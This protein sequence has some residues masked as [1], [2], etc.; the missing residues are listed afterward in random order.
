MFRIERYRRTR[1]WAVYEADELLCVAV[2]KKGATAVKERLDRVYGL[3]V[4]ELLEERERNPPEVP[5]TS[6]KRRTR[7]GASAPTRRRLP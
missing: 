2:Y 5:T 7:A 6:A 1:F 4:T 3:V